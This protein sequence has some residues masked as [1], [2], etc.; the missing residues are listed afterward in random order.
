[1][2]KMIFMVMA[3]LSM[4]MTSFAENDNVANVN[5]VE[6]YDMTINMRKLAVALDMTFDQMESVEDIHR[7]FCA[8]MMLAAHANK[9]E[10]AQLLDKAINKDLRYMRYVLDKDQYRKYL[11]LLNTTLH[12]RGLK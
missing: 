11:M 6:S 1:M 4:S 5:N 8:E 12:N 9:D 7:T 3:M 10:R 2:K